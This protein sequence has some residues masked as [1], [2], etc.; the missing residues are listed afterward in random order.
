MDQGGLTATLAG[1]VPLE[2]GPATRIDGDDRHV[3]EAPAMR[4]DRARIVGAVHDVVEAGDPGRREAR[5]RDR[6]PAVVHGG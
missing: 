4:L 6:R 5:R 1:H 2:T 3:A